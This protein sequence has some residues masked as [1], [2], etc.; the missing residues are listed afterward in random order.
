MMHTIAPIGRRGLLSLA[1]TAVVATIP[2]RPA[3]ADTADGAGATAPI[4]QLDTAL[5][6][7]MKAGR[8]TPF[9]QRYAALETVIEQTFDLNTVLAASVGLSWSAVPGDQ[10]AQLLNTFRRYTVASYAANF[11]N[12]NGQS[13]QLAPA[14]RSVGNGDVV[15]ATKL[16]SA[17]GETTPLD[18]VMRN[19]ATG[20]KVVDVLAAGSISRVAVQRSDFRHELASGGVPA[21][22]A[23]LQHKVAN[24]SDG[25]MA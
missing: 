3:A 23:A 24:L 6:A 16:V 19:G 4:R 15:V 11:D 2:W 12:Y 22:T 5:L 9:A 10:R 20:W 1:A 17:D 21:L 18:Y 7:A 14:V 13:F 8:G 25:A